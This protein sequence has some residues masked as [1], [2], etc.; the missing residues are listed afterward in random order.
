MATTVVTRGKI[1]V[2]ERLDRQLPA[3]WAVGE[4]GKPGTRPSKILENLTTQVGGGILPLGGQGEDFGG[5]K[6]YGLAVMVDILCGVLSGSAFGPEIADTPGS[7][8]RVSHF[9]GAIRVEAFREV[10]GFRRDM[11]RLLRGLRESTP[12]DG[13]ERVYYAGLKELEHEAACAQHG[14]SVSRK[15]YDQLVTTGQRLGVPVP[16][17]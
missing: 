17:T 8:A 15:V 13:E 7:S 14:V 2:Y 11:D 9:F 1:E 5:H 6:G 3:G 16:P 12:A 4:R 10:G